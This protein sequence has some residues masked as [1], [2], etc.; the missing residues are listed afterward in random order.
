MTF[1]D[2]PM[3]GW[4]NNIIVN[5]GN[6]QDAVLIN[7][8]KRS[9]AVLYSWYDFENNLISEMNNTGPLFY[10]NGS[11]GNESLS[12]SE[13]NTK[14]NFSGN[15]EKTVSETAIKIMIISIMSLSP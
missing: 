1:Y 8:A 7:N 14:Q 6:N 15:V 11:D 12:I 3:Y 13:V 2:K 10:V 5:Y 9:K 4:A